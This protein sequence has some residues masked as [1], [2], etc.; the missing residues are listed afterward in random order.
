MRR[1]NDKKV[2]NLSAI[3]KHNDGW[4][5]PQMQCSLHNV[6]QSKVSKIF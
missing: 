1:Q 2:E 4:K 5:S 3:K 6:T